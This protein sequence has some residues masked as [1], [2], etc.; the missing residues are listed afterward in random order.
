MSKKRG[1]LKGQ[2]AGGKAVNGQ[3]GR[4]EYFQHQDDKQY[5]R[6]DEDKPFAQ[7]GRRFHRNKFPV[8]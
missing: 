5:P 7:M 4:V 8:L 1:L 6:G 3:A 2:G